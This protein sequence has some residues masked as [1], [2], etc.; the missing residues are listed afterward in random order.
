MKQKP[1]NMI[2]I[3]NTSEQSTIELKKKNLINTWDLNIPGFSMVT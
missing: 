3:N 1:I 2:H